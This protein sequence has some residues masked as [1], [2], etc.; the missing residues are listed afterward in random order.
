MKM[1]TL[2]LR[3]LFRNGRRTLITLAAVAFGLVAIHFTITLQTGQYDAM[4]TKGVSTLAGHVVVQADG[5]QEERD[6]DLVVSDAQA[7]EASLRETFPDAVIAP[8]IMLGGLLNSPTNSIGV[9]LQAVAPEAEAKVQELDDK[10]V[11]GEWLS[12][13]RGVLVGAA[14]AKS[15]GVSVGDKVVYMGQHGESSEMASRMLRVRGI[16][17]TGAAE[18]DGFVAMVPIAAARDLL[19]GVDVAHQITVHLD[20]PEGARAATDRAAALLAD[21]DGL[22]ILHWSEAIPE[23]YALI[24]VDRA[25]GDVGL[26][27]LGIIVAMGV[28]NTVL[29]SALERTR[30]FGVMAALGM[31]PLQ[32]GRLILIEG[33]LLGAIGSAA[34]FVLGLAA[35][36]PLVEYGIDFGA[37]TGTDTIESAGVAIDAVMYGDYNFLRMGNYTLG[38][39]ALTTL[40]ALYPAYYV[41]RLKPVTAMRHH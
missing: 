10:L 26:V 20:N 5:Y 17:R 2:A 15:L 29:M 33:L 13:D 1:F 19:G 38:A 21:R 4:I 8:R 37:L 14:M 27:I 25:S 31:K 9:A 11:E 28:L 3:N 22:D 24:E 16:F 23:L 36:Y 39:I 18:M 30:E 7:I 12:D 35:S 34:G 32:L 41:A 6:S 40:A